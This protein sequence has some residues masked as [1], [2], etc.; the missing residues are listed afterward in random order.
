LN[1]W[2]SLVAVAV[3]EMVQT[4]TKVLLA[5]VVQE[6]IVQVSLENHQAVEEV[7]KIHL[8]CCW[9]RIIRLLSVVVVRVHIRPHR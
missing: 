5:V 3:D 7:P 8:L 2:S 9:P 4:R 6:D 1:T